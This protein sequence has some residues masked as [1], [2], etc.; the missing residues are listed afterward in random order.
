[1]IIPSRIFNP[2]MTV[3][4]S[5]MRVM[6]GSK[7]GVC[8]FAHEIWGGEKLE[9]PIMTPTVCVVVD[10]FWYGFHSTFKA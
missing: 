7:A 4:I 8:Y 9:G 1:M 6:N 10:S 5:H 2:L 3:L